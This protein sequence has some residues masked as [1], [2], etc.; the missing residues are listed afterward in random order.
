MHFLIGSL[1]KQTATVERLPG[2]MVVLLRGV[3]EGFCLRACA[4]VYFELSFFLGQRWKTLEGFGGD[5][6]VTALLL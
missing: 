5:A 1:A 3:L 6:L 2:W 4:R